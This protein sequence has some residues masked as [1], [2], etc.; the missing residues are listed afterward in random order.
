[1]RGNEEEEMFSIPIDSSLS[2]SI[3]N[4]EKAASKVKTV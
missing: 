1:M 4:H 2:T 3:K